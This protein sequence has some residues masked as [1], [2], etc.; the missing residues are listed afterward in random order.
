MEGDADYYTAPLDFPY[1]WQTPKA[2]ISFLALSYSW[3]TPPTL[4]F[5]WH[6]TLAFSSNCFGKIYFH[7]KLYMK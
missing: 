1:T 4:Y 3:P 2:L 6:T 5:S 7:L